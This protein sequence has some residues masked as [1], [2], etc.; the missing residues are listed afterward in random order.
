MSI[1]SCQQSHNLGFAKFLATLPWFEITVERGTYY[2]TN[3][4]TGGHVLSEF[5]NLNCLR[6]SF[7]QESHIQNEL[8]KIPVSS[9][10]RNVF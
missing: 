6:H 8:S 5:C 7:R 10:V 4:V 3:S 2:I 1:K 9:H